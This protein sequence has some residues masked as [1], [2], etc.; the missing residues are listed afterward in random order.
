M[1]PARGWGSFAAMATRKYK[2]NHKHKRGSHGTGPPRWFPSCDSLCPEDLD[3]SAA[4]ALLDE[5]IAGADP[6]HPDARALYAL[7]EGAFYK[8]YCEG[9]EQDPAHGTVEVWHGYPVR[10]EL[11]PRQVPAR[12][13]RK[14]LERGLLQPAEYR[15][16]LGGAP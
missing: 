11:V 2:P 6:A 8:A 5:G 12:V 10:P 3:L 1:T 13:L 15:R 7:H 9:T 14:F 16:L 4:Q